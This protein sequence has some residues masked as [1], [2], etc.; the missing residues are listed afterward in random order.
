LGIPLPPLERNRRRRNLGSIES[1]TKI[2]N[3][4]GWIP[5]EEKF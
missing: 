4:F 5:K 2:E 1:Y 3:Q